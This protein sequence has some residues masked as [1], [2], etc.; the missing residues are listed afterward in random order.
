MKKWISIIA[1]LAI[2]FSL[3]GCQTSI[4]GP[5]LSDPPT[6]EPS[7]NPS[8]APT[9]APTAPPTEPAFQ[10]IQIIAPFDICEN[11]P[12]EDNI[13]LIVQEGY[14]LIQSVETDEYRYSRYYNLKSGAYGFIEIVPIVLEPIIQSG[15]LTYTAKT[16]FSGFYSQSRVTY[17]GKTDESKHGFSWRGSNVGPEE[18]RAEERPEHIWVDIVIRANGNIVGFAVLEIV[19]WP[20]MGE[21]CYMLVDSYSECYQLVNGRFQTIDEDFVWQRIEQYH[22]Y[23]E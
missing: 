20:G 2:V 9:E 14:K 22:Q 19:D 11:A 6:E 5:E 18:V 12:E 23:A 16:N 13:H 4:Y 10:G 3:F 1:L 21:D 17:I 8:T 7:T 15:S